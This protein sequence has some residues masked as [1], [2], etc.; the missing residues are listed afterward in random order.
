MI[1]SINMVHAV[2]VWSANK[3]MAIIDS[4]FHK[5]YAPH[6]VFAISKDLVDMR[7]D[8]VSMGSGA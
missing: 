1:P 7:R 2:I 4:L 3:Q 6:V 8:F 5:Y